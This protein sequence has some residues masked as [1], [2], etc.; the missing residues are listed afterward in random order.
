[1]FSSVFEG[2]QCDLGVYVGPRALESAA[3]AQQSTK[4]VGQEPGLQVQSQ[5]TCVGADHGERGIS[6]ARSKWNNDEES[7]PLTGTVMGPG[8]WV[9]DHHLIG[10]RSM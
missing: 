3:G 9:T 6:S 7:W 10:D 5:V 8:I 2:S 4:N 1:M